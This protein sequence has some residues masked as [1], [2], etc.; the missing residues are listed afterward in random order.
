MLK[1][2]FFSLLVVPYLMLFFGLA[3]SANAQTCPHSKGSVNCEDKYYCGGC[4][5]ASAIPVCSTGTT[6]NCDSCAC[7]ACDAGYISCNNICQL[8]NNGDCAANHR[9][10]T[11][12]C[13][14]TCGICVS[15]YAECSGKCQAIQSGACTTADGN[16]GTLDQCG[17]CSLAKTKVELA[18]D[19]TQTW[20]SNQ[21]P[22]ISISQKGAGD[23]LKI[24]QGTSEK[25]IINNKGEIMLGYP[26]GINAAAGENMFFGNLNA[27]ALGNFFL[28]QKDGQDRF[29]INNEGNL[30]ISN[31]NVPVG[32]Y[33]F[34]GQIADSAGGDFLMFKKGGVSKL[35]VDQSGNLALAGNLAVAGTASIQG[36]NICLADGTNCPAVTIPPA[37][38]Q[39]LLDVLNKSADASSFSG[40]TILGGKVGIGVAA[41]IEKMEVNG[42]LKASG[43]VA[44]GGFGIDPTWSVTMPSLYVGNG[45]FGTTFSGGTTQSD[46]GLSLGKT[47]L[48]LGNNANLLYGNISSAPA[49]ANFIKM[50]KA[51]ATKFRVDTDGNVSVA[52]NLSVSGSY[53]N[54][55]TVQ[56][57]YAGKTAGSYDGNRGGYG[58]ADNYCLSYGAGAHVCRAGEIIDNISRGV[59]LI[60]S[61]TGTAWINNGA[62]G[63]TARANDCVGWKSTSPS[64]EDASIVYGAFWDF[65]SKDGW[66][67]SCNV[68]K[69]FACCK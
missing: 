5:D 43:R 52:G 64:I 44:F 15:G 18:P 4:V 69:P 61:E 7:G 24:Y 63:Y 13:D 58:Q 55:P 20:S 66:V 14:G 31:S 37:P 56:T 16:P 53:L 41:P 38:T 51:G 21:T 9:S 22:L 68:Q 34:Y 42:N 35:T 67:A 32:Q 6:L 46:S 19:Q 47:T 29:K 39:S 28:L 60:I 10:V 30:G 50:D 40:T 59:N 3:L 57:Q 48:N 65:D 8:P 36:K 1:K 2:N 54:I 33:L 27:T 62:P 45:F 25:F 49:S 26:A 17:N 23:L 12:Q 11:N